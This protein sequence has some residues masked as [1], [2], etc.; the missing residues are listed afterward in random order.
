M[1]KL[2]MQKIEHKHLTMRPRLKRLAR[3]PL[4]FS[5]RSSCMTYSLGYI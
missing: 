4:F 2:S 1:G 3:K 5:A